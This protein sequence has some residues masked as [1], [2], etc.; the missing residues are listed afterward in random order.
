MLTGK[1]VDRTAVVL[2]NLDLRQQL[3]ILSLIKTMRT[4]HRVATPLG[5]A[6]SVPSS[7]R[8]QRVEGTP[9]S[10]PFSPQTVTFRSRQRSCSVRTASRSRR[11]L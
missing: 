7:R 3:A 8:C 5:S 6:V 4:I 11:Q 9:Y 1:D 2:E 10:F